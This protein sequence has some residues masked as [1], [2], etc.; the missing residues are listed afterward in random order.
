M[1]AISI[2]GTA[3][4]AF[5]WLWCEIAPEAAVG[6]AATA[7]VRL[8]LAAVFVGAARHALVGVVAVVIG[9]AI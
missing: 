6:G 7:V 5:I 4:S 3:R 1:G 8:V 9:R 2:N